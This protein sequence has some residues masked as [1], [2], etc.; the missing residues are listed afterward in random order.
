MGRPQT[1]TD[2]LR[3]GLQ[4]I[5]IEIAVTAEESKARSPRQQWRL[6]YFQLSRMVNLHSIVIESRDL[7]RS[8]EASFANLRYLTKLDS[9]ALINP[10]RSFWSTLMTVA[11]NLKSLDLRPMTE[12]NHA[13]V[14]T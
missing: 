12:V 1:E 14:N 10:M 4:D 6:T 5:S 13:Q 11:P 7:D 9:L 3:T 2:N 8:K